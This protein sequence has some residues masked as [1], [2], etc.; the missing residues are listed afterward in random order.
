MTATLGEVR[1]RGWWYGVGGGLI[2]L[3]VAA[4]IVVFVLAFQRPLEE[5]RELSDQIDAMERFPVPGEAVVTLDQPGEYVVYA[6]GDG[7]APIGRVGAT[8]VTV[9]STTPDSRPLILRSVGIDETYDFGGHAGR[10][11]LEFTVDKPGDYRVTV[12][13]VPA[14]VT[15]VAVGPPVDLFAAIGSIFVV[16]F[17]PFA[18]GGVFVLAGVIVLVVTGVRRTS[19]TRRVRTAANP[20]A[21]WGGAPAPGFPTA[22]PAPGF[23]TAAP[24]YGY[25]PGAAPGWGASTGWGSP[26]APVAP[27]PWPPVSNDPS[28]SGP[29]ST[30]GAPSAAAPPSVGAP[31]P[32]DRPSPPEGG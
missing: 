4:A 1:P 2:G 11:A 21:A 14:S 29:D 23:P 8:S 26:P 17:V 10:S 5:F 20:P 7:I 32:S 13:Q 24:G 25:P 30:P 31:P 12:G 3:G 27:A 28:P 22:A 6:E 18:V 19:S 9:E 16:I 15:G